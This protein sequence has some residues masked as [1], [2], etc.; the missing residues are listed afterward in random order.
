[1]SHPSHPSNFL[2]GYLDVDICTNTTLTYLVFSLYFRVI[3]YSLKLFNDLA[4]Y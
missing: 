4:I 3:I 1:M 2:V